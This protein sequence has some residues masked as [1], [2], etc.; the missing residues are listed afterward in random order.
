MNPVLGTLLFA[1]LVA[2]FVG[3]GVHVGIWF[4]RER[5]AMSRTV[6]QQ[7]VDELTRDRDSARTI[8]E[9]SQASAFRATQFAHRAIKALEL[10]RDGTTTVTGGIITGKR[11]EEERTEDPPT[12]GQADRRLLDARRAARERERDREGTSDDRIAV[13]VKAS[14][15][16]PAPQLR[17]AVDDH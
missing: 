13:R 16:M 17:D 2:M 3:V 4:Q 7:R 14:D 8:A 12:T 10:A 5:E 1:I 15:M 11:G 9:A 6:L